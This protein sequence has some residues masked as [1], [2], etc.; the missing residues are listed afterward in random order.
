MNE[1]EPKKNQHKRMNK[2]VIEDELRT[3]VK[4]K[5]ERNDLR[6]FKFFF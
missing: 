6:E 1:D 4:N 3:K 2:N 5:T